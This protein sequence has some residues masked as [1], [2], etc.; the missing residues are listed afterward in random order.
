MNKL[1]FAILK[2]SCFC[3]VYTARLKRN[4][5]SVLMVKLIKNIIKPDN[6]SFQLVL[7]G[8]TVCGP[9]VRLVARPAVLHN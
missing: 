6:V 5:V 1:I 2:N 3:I 9:A 7:V 4:F 8:P